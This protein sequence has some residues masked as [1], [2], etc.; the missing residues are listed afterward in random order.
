M[1]SCSCTADRLSNFEIKT[2]IIDPDRF[3][4]RDMDVCARYPG[5]MGAGE[6]RLFECYAMARYVYI[7]L[8]GTE[9][10]TLC[11]VYVFGGR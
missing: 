7:Q 4:L 5:K 3:R 1:L 11:E 6:Y 2:T 8:K 10:L 9:Y